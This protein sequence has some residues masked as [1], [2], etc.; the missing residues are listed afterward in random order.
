M[1]V[2]LIEIDEPRFAL[3]ASLDIEVVIIR[4]KSQGILG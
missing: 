3:D 4:D 1:L 2:I